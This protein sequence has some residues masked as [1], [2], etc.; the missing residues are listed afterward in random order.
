MCEERS[1]E[2]NEPSHSWAF[3]DP[4]SGAPMKQIE[5]WRREQEI[6]RG[7]SGVD[8]GARKDPAA[9]NSFSFGNSALALTSELENNWAAAPSTPILEA[10]QK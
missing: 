6:D 5:Y 3:R 7:G 10:A 2:E 4:V 1:R 8:V 9:K